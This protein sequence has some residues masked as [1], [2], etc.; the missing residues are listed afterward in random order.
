MFG[1]ADC[2]AS[3]LL[4]VAEGDELSSRR[5]FGSP[6]VHSLLS[7]GREPRRRALRPHP[8]AP[9]R[10]PPWLPSA[11]PHPCPST[12]HPHPRFHRLPSPYPGPRRPAPPPWGTPPTVQP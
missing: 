4:P 5:R 7:D 9:P 1:A 3:F 11:R 12:P 2:G 8:S 10:T 6:M